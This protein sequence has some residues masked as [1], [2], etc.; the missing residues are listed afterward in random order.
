MSSPKSQDSEGKDSAD[1]N[2]AKDE[3]KEQPEQNP[4]PTEILEQPKAN[5]DDETTEKTKESED[6]LKE[7]KRDDQ[8]SEDKEVLANTTAQ[9]DWQAVYS[10]QY[11]AYYFYNTKTQETTWTNPLQPETSTSTAV[12][13]PQAPASAIATT[14]QPLTNPALEGIDPDLAYL[15]P[16]LA[17]GGPSN[18]GGTYAAKFNARTGRFTALDGRDPSHLSEYERAKRMSSVF[19]DVGAWEQE[20]AKRKAQED[21]DE[22]EGRR[23]KKKPSKADLVRGLLP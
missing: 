19:F 15:D 8:Q 11:N 9:H 5:A 7:E 14:S 17:Y 16:T 4:G 22:A 1:Q 12:E 21:A 10:P 20:V 23:R 13:I 2:Q 6:G 18:P 3:L